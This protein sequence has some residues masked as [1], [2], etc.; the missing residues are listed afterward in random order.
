M[1]DRPA[2]GRAAWKPPAPGTSGATEP[3]RAPGGSRGSMQP[4]RPAA[5]SSGADPLPG[6]SVVI[7]AR[8]EAA[9]LPAA[10]AS[11]SAQDYEGEIEVVVA[12]G[13]DE[14]ATANIVRARFPRVRL[15]ANPQRHIPAGLNHAVRAASH[16]VIVR[17]DARCVLPTDYVRVA[18]ATLERTGAAAVGG[19]QCPVG[20]G[21]FTRAVALAMTMRL[22]AGDARYRLGGGEGPADT[23]FLGVYR[24]EVLDAAG[25]FD[26]TLQRNEDYALNWRLREDGRT[27]WLDPRLEVVYRPRE[28]LGALARQYFANGWWKRIMLAR[29][30]RSLRWRQIAAPAL[31]L[32]LAGS[33]GLAAAGM[34]RAG[35][36]L[37]AAYLSVLVAGSALAGL[38]RRTAAA[39]LLP[40]VLATMHLAWAAGFW[41]ATVS[42]CRGALAG[43]GW[44]SGPK[45]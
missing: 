25:G 43:R 2:C 32:A 7:P 27:V 19:L 8:N 44:R 39:A 16:A 35:A 23:V 42:R 13:S 12:D 21:A 20:T 22:G 40:P 38:R 30:P 31:A 10:L 28:N 18:V 15:V 14:P 26:E 41:C 11:V 29:H 37:P 45:A 33:A 6:V 24:R 9:A 17:C 36:V 34:V 4:E 5:G 3:V 1:P